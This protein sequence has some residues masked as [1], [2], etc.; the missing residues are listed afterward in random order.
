M[1][2]Q[3]S[4]EMR[5]D[6]YNNSGLPQ[7][8]RTM[9]QISKLLVLAWLN[10]DEG[11]QFKH[12]INELGV[13][14]ALVKQGIFF[15]A[16]WLTAEIDPDSFLGSVEISEAS[17]WENPKKGLEMVFKIPYAPWPQ[18]GVTKQELHEWIE[19][20]NNWLKTADYDDPDKPFPVPPNPYIPLATS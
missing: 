1:S 8:R 17:S 15:P 16:D 13:H 18:T 6:R 11:E 10:Q 2:E 3:M 20:C 7:I 4:K 14:K 19:I 12:D 5:L 9:V